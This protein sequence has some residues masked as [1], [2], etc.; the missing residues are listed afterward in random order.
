MPHYTAKQQRKNFQEIRFVLYCTKAEVSNIIHFRRAAIVNDEMWMLTEHVDGGT[1][2]QA[3]TKYKFNESEVAYIA[4]ELLCGLKFLHNN[5]I[6]HRDMKSGNVV[7]GKNGDVKIID[8]GLCSDMST[9][10]VVH[11]VGSPFWL[12]PEMINHDPHGLSVDVWSF[13]ICCMEMV[14]SHPPYHR[15]TLRAM[16]VAATVGYDDPVEDHSKWSR[17]LH[18]FICRCLVKEPQARTSV[19]ELLEHEFLTQK[20]DKSELSSIFTLIFS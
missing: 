1:L 7:L 20:A 11:R 3:V 6:A 17:S 9:G 5:L 13:G 10:E 14:N 4:H 12:P 19:I 16:F 18:D 8:F 15:S 2:T